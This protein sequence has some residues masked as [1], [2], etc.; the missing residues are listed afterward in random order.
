MSSIPHH[1]GQTN[2]HLHCE[3]CLVPQD[4]NTE[5]GRIIRESRESKGWSQAALA[6]R[7]AEIDGKVSQ[8]AISAIERGQTKE[9]DS[10]TLNAI[11]AA[12][13][14]NSLHLKRLAGALTENEALSAIEQQELLEELYSLVGSMTPESQRR[15]FEIA[16]WLPQLSD[17]QQ[18]MVIAK[19]RELGEQGK[20]NAQL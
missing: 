16:L 6:E 20:T 13:E 7:I 3:E 4:E 9:P 19:I 5:L 17:E 14:L 15:F 12:L 8:T 2:L 11:A 18:E 1:N 10:R